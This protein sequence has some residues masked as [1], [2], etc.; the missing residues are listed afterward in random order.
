MARALLTTLLLVS[1]DA[2]AKEPKV[3]G[4]D[5]QAMW[6]PT[7]HLVGYRLLTWQYRKR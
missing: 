3:K 5:A 6:S 4:S 1:G 7:F 2:S